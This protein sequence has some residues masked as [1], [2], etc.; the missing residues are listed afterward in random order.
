MKRLRTSLF[1]L[2]F[3]LLASACATVQ[4]KPQPAPRYAPDRL[5]IIDAT[6]QRAMAD[7]RIIGG[8][9]HLEHEGQ[10]YEKVYGLKA[11]VPEPEPLTRDTIYDMASLTKVMATT[12]SIM[13]LYD[14][15]RIDLDAPVFRYIPEFR[16]EGRDKI[17]VRQLLTHTSGLR[18][19]LTL[20]D[21]WSGYQ[22]GI[23]LAVKEV[24]TQAPGTKFVYSDINF[25]LLGEIVARVS[26][27]PLNDFA[28]KMIYEPLGM[29]DTG[30]LPRASKR[31]RI[32]PTQY[33]ERGKMLLGV[34]HDPTSRRMGGIAGHAGLFTTADDLAKY[35]RMFLGYGELNGVRILQPQTVRLMTSIQTPPGMTTER[36]LGWDINTSFSRPRGGFPTGSYGHTGWTGPMLWIDPSSHSFYFFLTNRVH[37]NG[38][39]SVIQLQRS[40]GRLASEAI[41]RYDYGHPPQDAVLNGI[42]VLIEENCAPLEGKRIGLITNQT[43][44]D[45]S[46]VSTIDRLHFATKVR[47][48]SLFTPEHGIRGAADESVPDSVDTISGLPVYSLYGERKKPTA[49]EVKG[50]DALVYDIQD[51]GTRF[52]TYTSTMGLAMEA[53]HD[54]GIPFIVLDRIDPIDGVDVEGP[55][56]VDQKSFTAFHDVA[57]RYGMTIGELAKMFNQERSVGANLEIVPLRNWKRT[58]WQD[59]AGIPWINPSPNM[60]NLTEATLYPGIG[61]L[62]TTN[63]S[64]GRGTEAPFERIGAPWIDSA[65]LAA[66]L[67]ILSP[68]CI[69]WTPLDFTPKTSVFGGELVHGEKISV[70]SRDGCNTVDGGIALALSLQKLFPDAFQL[71]KM[72]HLLQD[73]ST[74][75]AIREGKSLEEIHA[76][77]KP[78]QEKFLARRS[79]YLMY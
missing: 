42:D 5:A 72:H 43:G 79:K 41:P 20:T 17:T 22:T 51:V 11:V 57:T 71:E 46:G 45:R 59:D 60:R 53:A 32:A 7:H 58:M 44:V 50:L 26:G 13:I 33:D 39:G 18:P 61:L 8:I 63:L 48:V 52:Y 29:T 49:D 67:K 35:A 65:K 78:E 14:Q 19:D 76:M 66:Q 70:V 21:W 1:A 47:L 25:E 12:P 73:Q 34:V 69:G 56:T 38:E 75:D 54:A 74:I 6:V 16:H 68:A 36:G 77:W 62:E 15:G 64:V 23:A 28:A 27:V 55:V 3:V 2:S 30:F 31:N 10:V 4:P 9:F 37:P 40:L 24:P